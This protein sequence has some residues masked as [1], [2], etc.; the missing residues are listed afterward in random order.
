[1]PE[2]VCR[3]CDRTFRGTYSYCTTCAFR[4]LPLE[5]RRALRAKYLYTRRARKYAARVAGPVPVSAYLRVLASGSCVY[6]GKP[7]VTVDHIT[8]LSRG[9]H[10]A[11]YNL[12]P[13]CW[14][15]NQSKSDRFLT[16]WKPEKTKH[17]LEHSTTVNAEYLRWLAEK[18]QAI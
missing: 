4:R 12:A 1:M 10:E 17:A 11:E 16:E 6:C 13:A 3:S 5:V 9:G 8:P 2:R 18:E 15:C 7:A 14:A